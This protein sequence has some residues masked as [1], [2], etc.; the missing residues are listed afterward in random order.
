[1]SVSVKKDT[2]DVFSV[3]VACSTTSNHKVIISDKTLLEL[4]NNRVTKT[5]LLE[6]SFKFLLAREPNT[7]I[8]SSFDLNMISRY[9]PDFND[10]VRRWC[11]R[12]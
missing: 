2:K 7:A 11:D 3:T 9:F 5:S 6:F 1:M 8:L 10:E 12:G 4:T